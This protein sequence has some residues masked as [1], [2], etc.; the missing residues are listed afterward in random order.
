MMQKKKI[1]N[2]PIVAAQGERKR[3]ERTKERSSDTKRK[4][5]H[6]EETENKANVEK[7]AHIEQAHKKK[8]ITKEEEYLGKEKQVKGAIEQNQR[9]IQIL[10][11]RIDIDKI[12]NVTVGNPELSANQDVVKKEINMQEQMKTVNSTSIRGHN[13]H[14][15][16]GNKAVAY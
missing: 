3:V 8:K 14:K 7:I 6:E 4:R 11:K 2:R 12:K 1:E 15:K 5:M 16:S 13:Q 10:M 9:E